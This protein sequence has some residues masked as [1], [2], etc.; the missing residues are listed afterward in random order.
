MAKTLK[1]VDIC[2]E[3]YLYMAKTLK[4]TFF[5]VFAMYLIFVNTTYRNIYMERHKTKITARSM[6]RR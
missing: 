5:S 4:N 3:Y 2:K 1:N 6:P